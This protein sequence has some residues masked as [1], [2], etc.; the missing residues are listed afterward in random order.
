MDIVSHD[1]SNFKN[2]LLLNIQ[3][4]QQIQD[5]DDIH[6]A[7]NNTIELNMI[8]FFEGF[9]VSHDGTTN[10][11]NVSRSPVFISTGKSMKPCL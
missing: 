11:H 3:I 1:G 8:F 9:L 5:K 10:P 7:A 6:K 2:P 4:L